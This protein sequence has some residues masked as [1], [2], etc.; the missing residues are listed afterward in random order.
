MNSD[1]YIL[2]RSYNI[3]VSKPVVLVFLLVVL[4]VTSQLEWKQ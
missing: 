1:V 4:I 2:V 3:M